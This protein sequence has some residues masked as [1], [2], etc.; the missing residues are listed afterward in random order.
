MVKMIRLDIRDDRNI[1]LQAQE[2]IIRLARLRDERPGFAAHPHV[3]A[4]L[5]HLA[6]HK[7]RRIE[8]CVLQHDADHRRRCRLAVRPGDRDLWP[9][10][11]RHQFA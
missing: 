10:V 3:A 7:H 11:C 1:R 4:Q 6:A 2:R 5:R 8:S 9:S